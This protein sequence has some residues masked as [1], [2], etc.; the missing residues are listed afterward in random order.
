MF[1]KDGSP[2]E[3]FV[4]FV[5]AEGLDASSLKTYIMGVLQ[6]MGIDKNKVIGQCYNRASVMSGVNA[7]VQALI[8]EECP[9]AV[10]IHCFTHCLNLVL[11]DCCK[12][13]AIAEDLLCL[14]EELYVFMS[15]SVANAIYSAVSNLTI[16]KYVK[17][18]GHR[19]MI[20]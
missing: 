14:L 4:E 10:Y 13:V 5:H 8:R 2:V 11:R 16:K 6:N 12:I 3:R 18:D 1:L 9:Y 19:V 15:H 20:V 17:L 7:G